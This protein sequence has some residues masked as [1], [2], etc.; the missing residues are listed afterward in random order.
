GAIPKAELWRY[1]EEQNWT[2]IRQLVDDP[3]WGIKEPVTWNRIPCMTIYQ[4]RLY[5]GISNCHGRADSD[6]KVD[7]GKVFA[8]EAGKCVSYD[9][10]LGTEWRHI[11]AVRASGELKLYVDG[12]LVAVSS[13]F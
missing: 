7:V 6:P 9:K 1:E 10:D 11:A 5:C 2:L 3:N 8:W 4:G 12:E 13:S